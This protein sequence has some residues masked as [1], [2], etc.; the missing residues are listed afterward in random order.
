MSILTVSPLPSPRLEETDN[1]RTKKKITVDSISLN[2]PLDD[3]S[4]GQGWKLSAFCPRTDAAKWIH[5]P[6]RQNRMSLHSW[7]LVFL[8]DCSH[9]LKSDGIQEVVGSIPIGS[10]IRLAVNHR[11]LMAGH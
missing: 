5:P 9:E 8:V 10:T 2:G 1:S 4:S 11:S 7:G 3:L 6:S